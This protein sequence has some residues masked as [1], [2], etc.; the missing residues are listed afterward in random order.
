MGHYKETDINHNAG[1]SVESEKCDH[2][3][4]SKEVLMG[5][6]TGDYVCNDCYETFSPESLKGLREKNKT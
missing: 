6:K 4:I 3:R 5:M 1:S 2:K